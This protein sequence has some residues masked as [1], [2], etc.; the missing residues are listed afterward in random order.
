M[1]GRSETFVRP[2]IHFQPQRRRC[3]WPATAG[4]RIR[5]SKLYAVRFSLRKPLRF[6][7]R[8]RASQDHNVFVQRFRERRI[9]EVFDAFLACFLFS[10]GRLF[11]CGWFPVHGDFEGVGGHLRSLHGCRKS[12]RERVRS[13]ERRLIAPVSFGFQ[14][15][16]SRYPFRSEFLSLAAALINAFASETAFDRSDLFIGNLG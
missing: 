5:S 10:F 7:F 8:N 13:I 4:F 12:A 2:Q 16:P 15:C 11:E 9:M 6:P 1:D 3:R 14:I